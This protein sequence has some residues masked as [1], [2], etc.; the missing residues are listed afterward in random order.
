MPMVRYSTWSQQATVKRLDARS[1]LWTCQNLPK[2][3]QTGGTVLSKGQQ[4]PGVMQLRASLW[5]PILL[6]K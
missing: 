1:S 3:L 6:Q 5:R 4:Q 2:V